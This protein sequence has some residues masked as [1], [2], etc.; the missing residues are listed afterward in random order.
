MKVKSESEVTQ[1]CL[2]LR[3]PMDCSPPGFSVHGVFQARVLERGAIAMKSFKLQVPEFLK[4]EAESQ[5][6]FI[7]AS[8]KTQRFALGH[9][10]N[11][12][13]NSENV[14]LVLLCLNTTSAAL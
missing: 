9:T 10:A 8:V 5:P 6:C 7:D 1:S 13:L 3:D 4:N 12:A 2:T 14:T 11:Q